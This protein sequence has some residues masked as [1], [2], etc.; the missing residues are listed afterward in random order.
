MSTYQW[1][2]VGLCVL[3]NT[4]DGY[5]V[6]AMSFTATRVQDEFGL[7]GSELGVVIS[8]TL[9]GMAV[10]SLI[11]GLVADRIGRRPT[12]L[13]SVATATVGMFLAATAPSVLVL[14]ICRVITGL[15]IGGILACVTI[16]A[17]EYSSQRRRGLAIGLY[18]AGYGVGA[19]VGGLV[20][21]ALQ[22]AHGWRSV[23]L[24]GAVVSVI[25]LIM[26]IALLPE[27]VDFLVTRRPRD[28]QVRL[29]RIARRLGQPVEA[30]AVTVRESE[31]RTA[32]GEHRQ[33]T[34]A[35]IA[36]LFGSTLRRS[37]LLVWAAFF[38]TMFGFYFVNSWTPRLLVSAGMTADQGVT[39]G[40]ALALGGAV[41]SV[42]Y[43]ALAARV[44]RRRLLVIFLVLSAAMV[45]IFV[46]ST[47]VLSMA[48]V[49][50]GIIGLL[51]NGCVAG[52]Y[53][54]TPALY[55]PDI[56]ATGVGVALGIGRLGAM[57]APISAGILLDAAW[58]TVQL[59]LAVAVMFV[60][61]AVAVGFIRKSKSDDATVSRRFAAST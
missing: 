7:T 53:T 32:G 61:G 38:A 13:L 44:A 4:L 40:V 23:F 18:T 3:L 14:G 54:I 16:I 56:R 15:G 12:I 51:V 31:Q 30:A 2:I 39:V 50:G 47:A 21:V 48:F 24:V 9:I 27:S 8:G 57:L 5:D 10:G 42:L 52:L 35:G 28:L 36:S 29:Q 58:T 22:S 19:T 11:L 6:A 26:L 1:A 59:Y 55:R 45:V 33:S 60:I 46:L 20:A 37:T 34:M 17:S 43:G 25:S 49:L 41:G